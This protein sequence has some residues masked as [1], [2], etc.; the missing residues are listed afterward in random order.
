MGTESH[1]YIILFTVIIAL[2][3]F[4]YEVES[5]ASRRRRMTFTSRRRSSSSSSSSSSSTARNRP[6]IYSHTPM[7]ATSYGSPIIRKQAKSRSSFTRG[8]I[9]GAV[10]YYALSRAPLYSGRYPLFSRSYVDIPENRAVRLWREETTVTDHYGEK[11]VNTSIV[12]RFD[13][14]SSDD[15]YLNNSFTTIDYQNSRDSGSKNFTLDASR[16]GENVTVTS[17]NDYI[18]PIIPRTNCTRI[19]VTTTFTL[20][21]MYETNPNGC[22][23]VKGSFT[24][25]FV[26]SI[27]LAEIT[28]RR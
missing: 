9:G 20:I 4:P 23:V 19:T 14:S 27:L 17:K 5:R 10:A 8:L 15:K 6:K 16:S 28:R 24:V 11:C 26:I 13:Y 2:L 1:C 22:G 7:K 18:K 21:E 12:P 3:L 25:V